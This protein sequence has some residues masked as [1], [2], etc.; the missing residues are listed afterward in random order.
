M[1]M[2]EAL[3][4]VN[5]KVVL[6]TRKMFGEELKEVS[7]IAMPM[8]VVTVSQYLLRVSPMIML[9]HLGELQLSSASI[10]T[11]LSNVTGFSLLF[12]MASALETLCGQA[13]GAGQYRKLGTFTYGAIICLFIVCIPVSVLWIFTD[14]LL[15]LMGQDPAIATEAG[16]YAIWL[17]PTLFPYAILQ[18][19]VRY[20]Q[21]QSLILPMLLSAVV[22][23]CLQV[24]ICWVFIFKLGL[25]NAGA[26]MSIGLS[27]WLNV[28]LLM[29][30]VKYSSTCAKTRASFSRDVFL[31]IGDFFRF[32][33]PSAVMVCL[34]WWSF[35]L[36]ILLS[37]L[38]PNPA[39]ETS[40]LS[41]C[42][43][44]TSVHYH[45]PYSFGAAASTRVSNEL[46]A[47]RPQAA[48]VALGA[49][50]ILSVAE[51]ILASISIFAVRHV[52]GYAFTFE[53]EVITY[54]AEITPILCISIIMDGT[55]AVLSGVARGSGWQHIG[56]YV[57]LGAY[58]L[59]GIPV[60]LLLGFVLHLKGKG[61]WI[62]LVA[63]ATVQS[64]SLSL[65]TGFT[66][67]EKQAIEARQRIFSGKLAV[68]NQF[69]E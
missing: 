62:G 52:W 22:S 23:L 63:G 49:V 29:L 27:Y 1:A 38:L 40:V 69:I 37:G 18:S 39:L 48:K 60:A 6:V 33:I 53:K 55:Q 67:W 8:I 7:R 32:A 65:I 36:I 42:F 12:G 9:G 54:V 44:T 56:A 5:N 20:L 16:K 11:S 2:E 46:G 31:T 21:A 45:I 25:G 13:Y 58:Y 59:V 50:L 61:L 66:N 10:A 15:I 43:T 64:I 34:E 47:G 19:L 28:I 3:L 14:K 41:I 26:A 24:P 35:E 17:I 4:D 30:Y 57:N 68:E 51:V